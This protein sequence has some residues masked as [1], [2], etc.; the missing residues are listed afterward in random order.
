[1]R[2]NRSLW[3]GLSIT[4]LP[5]IKA[6]AENGIP[7]LAQDLP[8]ADDIGAVVGFI[9]HHHHHGVYGFVIESVRNGATEAAVA[10]VLDRPE[11]RDAGADLLE[12]APGG[13]RAAIVHDH[14]FVGSVLQ[15]QFE[16]EVLNGD[17]DAAFFVPGRNY[18]GER[19]EWFA[20]RGQRRFH[21]RL[22]PKSGWWPPCCA[23]PSRIDI[24]ICQPKSLAASGVQWPSTGSHCVV[25]DRHPEFGARCVRRAK[26]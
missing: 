11:F 7:T 13:V 20:G 19:P 24:S 17:G 16:M 12:Q 4:P 23:M 10:E 22:T 9:R 3:R 2:L 25:P 18:H 14:D 1:M 15:A 5:R 21:A 6:R 8:V 26:R